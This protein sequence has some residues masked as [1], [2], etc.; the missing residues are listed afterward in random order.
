ML[1]LVA[2][3]T[4][5]R[6]GLDSILGAGNGTLIVLGDGQAVRDLLR[7]GFQVGLDFTPAALFQLAKLDGAII[8][9]RDG[10]RISFANVELVP[11]PSI[12]TIETGMRHRAGERLARQTGEL[13]IAVS[14]RRKVIT[15]YRGTVRYVLRDLGLVLNRSV[16]ALQALERYRAA[17]A[18][19]AVNLSALEFEDLATVADASRVIQRAQLVLRVRDEMEVDI[20]ELGAEGR[21]VQLQ[22]EELLSGVEQEARLVVRDY[23]AEGQADPDAVYRELSGWTRDELMDLGAIARA[24]GHGGGSLGGLD[25]AVSPRGHRVLHKIPRLP[26]SVV[27]N[28]VRTFG[29]LP[30]ILRATPEELDAVEGIGEARARAIKEGL[31]RLRDQVLFDRQLG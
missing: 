10:R 9:S 17:F 27:E 12:P 8:L 28:L 19:T 25:Q 16:Q 15:L 31:R 29:S 11:D 18:Q 3:G 22:L 5:L 2:P 7:G 6:E 1:R 21:L 26:A 4:P 24:L 30:A 20:A 23:L 13:V 14:E